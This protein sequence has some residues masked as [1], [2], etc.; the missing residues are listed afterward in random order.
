MSSVSTA[1]HRFV[2]LPERHEEEATHALFRKGLLLFLRNPA[3]ILG[4]GL[5]LFILIVSLLGPFLYTVAPF[6]IAGAPFSPPDGFYWFGTDY[7]GRDI[8]A[9][10]I[11]GGRTTLGVGAAAASVSILTGLILGGLSGYFGGWLDTALTKITELFQVLPPLLFAMV[12]LL[13]F[14]AS[15]PVMTLSIGLVN[16]IGVARLTRAEFM[17]LRES[18]FVLAAVIAG[19][20]PRYILLKTILPNA[21]PP[22]IVASAFA[23]G[24]A[25]L[26][27]GSLSFLGLS[28]PNQLSWGLMI[29]QNRE[30]ILGAW[31]TVT[32]PG[33]AIFL[34]VLSVCLIGDALNDVLNPL[35]QKRM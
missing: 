20:S 29:G 14:G 15:F 28:D 24:L 22:I 6:E 31:W 21:S 33:A 3:G 32:I 10:I 4:G 23:I 25:I 17:R 27:E 2:C 26:F 35:A 12:L 5:F 19:A 9:G 13:L 16:W 18:D 34:A 11:H 7:I 8:F 1:A 30:Y